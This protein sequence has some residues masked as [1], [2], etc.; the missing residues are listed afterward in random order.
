M[1]G[2]VKGIAY[3]IVLVM[4][5]ALMAAQFVPA[6]RT[7]PPVQG[8]LQAPLPIAARLRR[9]CYDCHSNETRWPW[10]SHVAPV[11]WLIIRD[12]N[13][14]REEINFSEWESYYP[15]T[16]RRKLEWMGRALHEKQMPPWSYRL[17][18]PSARLS[19]ADRAELQSWIESTLN[20]SSTR[21]WNK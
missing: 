17:M 12:V 13:L 11:S 1:N 18:H 14:G 10:Y 2:D 16:R 21:T 20:T 9:A 7:N 3:T 8:S 4:V 6:T 15:R 5:T 19:E